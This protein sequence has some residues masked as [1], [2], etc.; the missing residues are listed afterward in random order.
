MA[1]TAVAPNTRKLTIV[2]DGYC[3]LCTHAVWLLERLDR[4]QLLHAVPSQEPATL[5]RYG[6]TTDDVGRAVWVIESGGARFE[7]AAAVN[8]IFQALG[9]AGSLLAFFYRVPPI[10]WFEDRL[11]AWVSQNRHHFGWMWKREAMCEAPNSGC[12]PPWDA[13]EQAQTTLPGE[14][15][16]DALVSSSPPL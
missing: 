12:L 1:V 6:L 3:R 2:F 10:R 9:G 16:A 8:R 4:R 15:E 5:K 7:G 11:Y 13:V 14:P